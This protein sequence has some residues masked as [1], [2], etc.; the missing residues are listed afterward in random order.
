MDGR[1]VYSYIRTYNN[2]GSCQ[3][4]NIG[5]GIRYNIG[6]AM[7]WNI[8]IGIGYN[9]GI[10]IRYNISNGITYNIG[11]ISGSKY[12]MMEDNPPPVHIW[13]VFSCRN[14]TGDRCYKIATVLS[15]IIRLDYLWLSGKVFWKQSRHKSKPAII[16]LR[17]WTVTSILF[18]SAKFVF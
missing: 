15:R 5:I 1:C 10:R 4:Y 6:I 9:T 11:I 12:Q 3:N 13:Q 8:V 17:N 14:W 16:G 7:S 18:H 2:I